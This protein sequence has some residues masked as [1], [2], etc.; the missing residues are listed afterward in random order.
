VL[1]SRVPFRCTAY[2]GVSQRVAVFLCQG[3]GA[4]LGSWS[5]KCPQCGTT[6]TIRVAPVKDALLNRVV[7]QKY[8]I[9]K[10]LGQ[11]GMGAVY[12]GEQLGIGQKVALKFLK[13]EFSADPELARRF[14]N[15]AKSY[16]RV[17]HPNA[18]ALH[19]FGQDEEGNLFIAMEYCEGVDLKRILAQQKRLSIGES[20][21]L[22]LQVAD[23]LGH[24]HQRGIVH[25]DLKPENIMVRRGMRGLH[26][27]VLD[28][29]I[30]RL[31][32]DGTQLTVAGSIAG[33]PRYMSPEQ[34]EGKEADLRADIYSLGVVLF[35]CVTGRQPFDGATVTDI[36]RKQ[37][38]VPMPHLRDI[39][40]ELNYPELDNVIQTA[41]AKR[42]ELRWGD[43]TRFAT[44]LSEALPTQTGVPISTSSGILSPLAMSAH[45]TPAPFSAAGT[46]PA[47]S[48]TQ[49]QMS[50][51][52]A[53]QAS[54][55]APSLRASVSRS[56]VPLAVLA[57]LLLLAVVGAVS[58]LNA[59]RSDAVL[60]EPRA[61]VPTVVPVV[62][63]ASTGDVVKAN[64]GVV[65][66]ASRQLSEA[67]ARTT[68]GQGKTAFDVGK[69]DE[70]ETYL[71]SVDVETSVAPE[72]AALLKRIESIRKAVAQAD[73]LRIRGQCPAAL[74]IYRSA[75]E[76]NGRF[77]DALR[78]AASCQASV[79][80]PVMDP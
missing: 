39:S 74:P 1:D 28:F 46:I 53:T 13:S 33:T 4:E 58:A 11:G 40:P 34:V 21:E 79:I 9:T 7:K 35:E 70:S 61:V 47:L 2:K 23:V 32:N 49:T 22:C 64:A 59:R 24:A 3:C 63:G 8:R 80:A 51:S 37:V 6:E 67:S 68:L 14:L 41:C 69:L 16:A 29:G 45:L 17:A 75:L 55:S 44:A 15:E 20:I 38:Q 76:L 27:K 73:A 19:D 77:E 52:D 71:K 54:T 78:G 50:V 31:L 65:K 72:A 43:M 57:A 12:L 18:V 60:V 66:E 25:R 48:A 36:M 42:P 62:T 10:K 5:G 30:A 26:A 56:K